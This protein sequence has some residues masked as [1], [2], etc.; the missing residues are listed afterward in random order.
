[1]RPCA[2]AILLTIMLA[3]SPACVLDED[4]AADDLGEPVGGPVDLDAREAIHDG[5]PIRLAADFTC[6]DACNGEDPATYNVWAPGGQMVR[7][8]WDA[9]TVDE[10]TPEDNITLQLR[11]SP[12]CRTIW[13]RYWGGQTGWRYVVT[14]EEFGSAI[15]MQE[16]AAGASHNWSRMWNDAGKV[17]QTCIRG[18]WQASSEIDCTDGY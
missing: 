3:S 9:V 7:C 1:M 14:L 16:I 12:A 8:A 6:G 5:E 17:I 18:N 13:G 11:Y 4:L 15:L 2:R 10:R